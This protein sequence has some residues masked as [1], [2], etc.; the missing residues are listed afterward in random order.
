MF[1]INPVYDY[2]RGD[3]GIGE[4]EER[5]ALYRRCQREGVGIAVMKA[6]CGGQLLDA[7]QSPFGVALTRNQCLQYALDMPGV[8]TVLPGYGNEAELTDVLGYFQASE[9]ER[10]YSCISSFAPASALG[11]CVY[12][13][14][15]HPCPAG[16]DIGLINKYCD[17][18]R[19]G[20]DLAKEHYRTL[21]KKAGDCLYC[22][23][24]D[25]RCPFRVKQSERMQ[26]ILAY[27]GE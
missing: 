12:C 4:N 10:D 13:R 22:G 25:R 7:A 24:C 15:C 8:L 19:M 6:F 16:L 20:D 9:A 17:L 23:H 21:E 11:L 18:A 5:Y 2:G 1:S 3:F 14:H 26:E 27:F